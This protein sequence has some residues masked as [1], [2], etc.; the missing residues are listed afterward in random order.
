MVCSLS[1]MLLCVGSERWPEQHPLGARISFSLILGGILCLH[2]YKHQAPFMLYKPAPGSTAWV[3]AAILLHNNKISSGM[4]LQERDIFCLA[5]VWFRFSWHS[6]ISGQHKQCCSACVQLCH[7]CFVPTLDHTSPGKGHRLFSWQLCLDRT[8]LD[9]KE[10]LVSSVVIQFLPARVGSWGWVWRGW[11]L[12]RERD[13]PLCLWDPEPSTWCAGHK[14]GWL[15][16]SPTSWMRVQWRTSNSEPR[17]PR[18]FHHDPAVSVW[19]HY[20]FLLVLVPL[21]AP[22]PPDLRHFSGVIIHKH[23]CVQSS[24]SNSLGIAEAQSLKE[25]PSTGDAVPV[26]NSCEWPWI[27]MANQSKVWLTLQEQ[28]CEDVGESVYSYIVCPKFASRQA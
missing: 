1:L 19:P 13:F 3:L 26:S 6:V 14:P 15:F 5:D 21:M 28:N 9:R 10:H 20:C 27:F 22:P 17:E 8:A 7:L 24:C 12:W 23:C 16:A 25:T 2:H 11:S 4:M 18:E